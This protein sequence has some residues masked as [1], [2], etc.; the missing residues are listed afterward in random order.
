MYG[1]AEGSLRP[2]VA[3]RMKATPGR[4]KRSTRQQ[5]ESESDEQGK[6]GFEVKGRGKEKGWVATYLSYIGTGA[7]NE[8]MRGEICVAIWKDIPNGKGSA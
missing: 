6:G 8:P 4:S 2:C 7:R 1:I 3:E 5:P